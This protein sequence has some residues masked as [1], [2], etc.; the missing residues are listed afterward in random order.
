M[1]LAPEERHQTRTLICSGRRA[2]KC[3]VLNDMSV[4][5]TSESGRNGVPDVSWRR[6]AEA[7]RSASRR[8]SPAGKGITAPA[9]NEVVA[10]IA[11]PSAR[12]R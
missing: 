11:I 10:S 12:A 7:R 5:V 6:K 3:P 1:R 2:C 8:A 9:V 4:T